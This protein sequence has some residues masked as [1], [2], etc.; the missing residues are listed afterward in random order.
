MFL[1][2]TRRRSAYGDDEDCRRHACGCARW[3]A[4]RRAGRR[5]Q[6]YRGDAAAGGARAP[7]GGVHGARGRP[8]PDRAPARDV[9]HRAGGLRRARRRG[10]G[11][12]RARIGGIRCRDPCDGACLRG[13]RPHRGPA[14]DALG[15]RPHGYR[16][17]APRRVAL[18]RA[19]VQ[20]FHRIQAARAHPRP[21]VPRAAPPGAREA[22]RARQRRPDR[23]DHLG[24]RA[25]R[26]LLRP[27]H[28]ARADRHAIQRGAGAVHRVVPSAARTR[29]AFG[30]RAGGGRRAVARGADVRRGGPTLPRGVRAPERLCARYP[31]W[32]G[33]AAAIRC[34]RASPRGRR[35]SRCRARGGRA[36]P[37]AL[38]A[39]AWAPRMR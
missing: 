34:R 25:A 22:R 19:G 39:R 11:A 23:R 12:E 14:G 21:R 24:Y 3:R 20:P 31:A 30:L 26:G 6:R 8:R 4:R 13:A 37:Q 33:R 15:V 29:G 35:P 36:R 10:R 38:Q 5:T 32:Y 18:R 2:R 1:L 9:H 28:L 16:R 7:H 27:H 17:R